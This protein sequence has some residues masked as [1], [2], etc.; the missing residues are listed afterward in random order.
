VIHTVW[1]DISER[2]EAALTLQ[3]SETRFRTLF[4]ASADA[5]LILDR[6]LFV[7]C[8][9]AT[10]KMLGATTKEEV[11][12]THPSQLSPEFQ[13]DGRSSGE[14]ADEMIR[15]A[16]EKGSNRFEWMHRRVNGKDFPVEYCSHPSVGDRYIIHTVWRD[17]TER[18]QAEQALRDN[19]QVLQTVM[20]NIP[21]S[22][23][24]K[25]SQLTY[26]GCNQAFAK[27][28]GFTSLSAIIGK[29]DWD[30]S[31]KDRA[32]LY[33][34]DDM[35]VIESGIPRFNFEERQ[36]RP[37][38]STNWLRTSKVPLRDADG[39]VTAVLG[40]YEDITERKNLEEQ[41]QTA[42]ERQRR[43]VELSTQTSQSIAASTDLEDL[44]ERVVTQVTERFGYYHTQILRYEPA[45]NTVVLVV[46][47]GEVG[48]KMLTAEHRLPMGTGLIGTAASTGETVLRPSLQNDPDW[49][50]NPL[51][52]NTKGEVAVPIKLGDTILGV[53]DVQSDVAGAL[54]ADDQLLLEGLCGQIAVAIES[55]R[56]RQEMNER[57]SEIN[58]LYQAMRREGWQTYQQTGTM[59]A[60]FMFDQS[61]ILPLDKVDLTQDFFADIPIAIPGGDVIGSVAVADDPEH[62]LS[63]QERDLLG[64]ITEQLALALES[65]RL[66]D[67]TQS[68]LVQTE[69]LFDSSR[70][71]TQATDLQELVASFVTAL[72][73][74]EVNRALLTSFDY[75]AAGEV[76]QLTVTANWWNGEG[77]EVTPIGTKY[78]LE[79]IQ[80][81]P[82]FVSPIPVFFNDT[83]SDKRVDA[84]T[85]ELVKKLNLRAVAVLPLQLGPQQIGALVLEAEEPHNFTTD[86]TRLFAS[87]GPQIATIL[88]NRQQYEKAQ[89]QAKREAML[90][91][92]NQKIQSATTVDAVLQIAARELGSALGAPLTIA[93]LGLKNRSNG[94]SQ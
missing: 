27:D 62:P 92:I 75:D 53:L 50:P 44:Y 21:Q 25:D 42:F 41:K 49:K 20:D 88:E 82:M 60:G 65:A 11:L 81:M 47:Y 2:K 8:N 48:A 79:V 91:I 72:G 74:S 19:Q 37:D 26:L 89:Y 31:S 9:Q 46:G 85:M 1:R 86:E 24:W 68:A 51:L 39:K 90:N 10:V 63:S 16:L 14:K 3:E 4:E 6:N 17:I 18:K 32:E 52:P 64:Q 38:G 59:P 55:T 13:P 35:A 30:M 23:F 66:F 57:L 45:Q 61:G 12:S 33:R 40:M 22:I 15:I 73:I 78:P 94:N 67:Q 56:L 70:R 7:D 93:Q 84:T 54:S 87:L 28:L 36:T 83:F 58:R 80:V 5:Y 77:T 69:R 34:A 29:N 76:K 71:L 43:R